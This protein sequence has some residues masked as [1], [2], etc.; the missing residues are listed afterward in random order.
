MVFRIQMWA[1]LLF[2]HLSLQALL[3]HVS[4]SSFSSLKAGD[5]HV[6]LF[7]TF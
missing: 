4:M 6:H 7:K 5:V 3:L 2:P 1:S